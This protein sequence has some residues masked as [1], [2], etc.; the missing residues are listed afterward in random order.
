MTNFKEYLRGQREESEAIV[1]GNEV[2]AAGA[3]MEWKRLKQRVREL[4]EGESYNGEPF[5]WSPY[6]APYPE[7]LHVGKVAVSFHDRGLQGG[8]PQ[9]CM[10]SFGRR[11]LPP[12]E[13]WNDDEALAIEYWHIEPQGKA[14]RVEWS[15]RE[16]QENIP[17]EQLADKILIAFFEYYKRYDAAFRIKYR[18]FGL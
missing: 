2:L 3:A 17:T 9:K 14:G 10:I 16:L 11:P 12:N 18:D 5:L 6:P 8:I 13:M 15:I 4:A 1:R 7:F